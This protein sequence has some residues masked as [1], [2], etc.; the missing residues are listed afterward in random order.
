MRVV[1]LFLRLLG[2]CLIASGFWWAWHNISEAKAAANASLTIENQ[3]EQ[4]STQD[5][6]GSEDG[7]MAV[8]TVDGTDY[9]GTIEIPAIGI[10]LPVA[11][12][13]SFEQMSLTPTRYA[14]SFYTNDLVICAHNY[15]YHFDSL[16][17]IAMGSEVILTTTNGQTYHYIITNRETIEPTAVD[18]V[19][20]DTATDTDWDLSLFT[21]TPA[22]LARVLVRCSL[23]K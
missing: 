13:Y 1:K 19:F 7:E 16:K 18:Q 3:L 22:G 5:K 10:K 11:A 15:P 14:G 17:S 6:T 9:I 12:N 23:V 21:C 4:V 20:K 2:V 8:G